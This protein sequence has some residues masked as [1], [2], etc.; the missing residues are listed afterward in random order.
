MNTQRT[1]AGSTTEKTVASHASRTSE[2]PVSTITGSAPR[3]T[4]VLAERS[5][6][7]GVGGQG[8]DEER[9]GG[10]GWASVGRIWSM[11]FDLSLESAL[12]WIG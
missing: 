5:A 1:S 4:M 6:A 12:Y 8:R 7:A 11:A 3:I 10:D 9:V 2:Q